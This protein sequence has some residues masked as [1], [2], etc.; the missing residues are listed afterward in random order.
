VPIKEL[1][2]ELSVIT[3]SSALEMGTSAAAKMAVE[4]AECIGIDLRQTAAFP[5]NEAA[6]MSGAPNV[7]NSARRGVP[8]AFEVICERVEV[9]STDSAAQASQ[10]LGSGKELF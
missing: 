8:F 5:L 7:S 6:E 2:S 10:R 9:C 3:D 1:H 4:G